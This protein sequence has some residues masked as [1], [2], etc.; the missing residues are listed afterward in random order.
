MELRQRHRGPSSGRGVQPGKTARAA[1]TGGDQKKERH[2]EKERNRSN[3]R[4]GRKEAE[5]EERPQEPAAEQ[6]AGLGG[7]RGLRRGRGA[8]RREANERAGRGEGGALGDMRPM[9]GW[10]GARAGH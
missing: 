2:G 10:A 1:E 8:R 4:A 3:T 9:E 6:P 7:E 5:T